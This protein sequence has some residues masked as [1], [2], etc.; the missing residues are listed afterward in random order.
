[1]VAPGDISIVGANDSILVSSSTSILTVCVVLSIMAGLVCSESENEVIS[2]SVLGT[3]TV[4]TQ[5]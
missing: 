3:V 1:M 5:S 4:T 2:V